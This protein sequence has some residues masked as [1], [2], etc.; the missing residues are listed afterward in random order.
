MWGKKKSLPEK[1]L[2]SVFSVIGNK[3]LKS[4]A[5]T[6][7]WNETIL[8]QEL[9]ISVFE[10][11]IYKTAKTHAKDTLWRKIITL[12]KPCILSVF[13]HVIYKNA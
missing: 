5:I 12:Q 13:D 4:R 11:L 7:H 6:L 2:L 9:A 3:A 1:R 10:L 8:Y